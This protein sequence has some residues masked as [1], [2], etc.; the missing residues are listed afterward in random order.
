ML[1]NRGSR[2]A[3]I[4]WGGGIVRIC[5]RGNC[6]ITYW[7]PN[8]QLS[9]LIHDG[10]L[11][12]GS[13]D[14]H[15]VRVVQKRRS[16]LQALGR[17]P[18]SSVSWAT[19][20]RSVKCM[21]TRGAKRGRPQD[22]RLPGECEVHVSGC[23]W[24][25]SQVLNGTDTKSSHHTRTPTH[26]SLTSG[27]VLLRRHGWHCGFLLCRLSCRQPCGW[28]ADSRAGLNRASRGVSYAMSAAL[29]HLDP[30]DRSH[31]RHVA[32]G[33]QVIATRSPGAWPSRQRYMT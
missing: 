11:A 9:K 26:I 18:C 24:V 33:G 4:P 5:H 21:H 1:I 28:R 6:A 12:Y 14:H 16:S 29:V 2:L 22:R 20:G 25:H 15:A 10:T 8:Y 30:H 19:C 32:F 23:R 31:W 7:D 3:C 17:A 27:E 13:H